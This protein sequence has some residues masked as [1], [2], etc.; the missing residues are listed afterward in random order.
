MRFSGLEMDFPHEEL[1]TDNDYLGDSKYFDSAIITP[2]TQLKASPKLFSN[3]KTNFIFKTKFSE[4]TS[5]NQK[6]YVSFLGRLEF[7][8]ASYSWLKFSYSLM[9]RYYLRTYIDRDVY[10][11]EYHPCYF[12]NETVYISYST[13]ISIKKTWLDFKFVLNNQFYNEHFTEYDHKIM[14][15]EAAVKSKSFKRLALSAAY[16]FYNADNVSYQSSNISESTKIDR[17]YI[18]NGIKLSARKTLKKSFISSFGFKFNFSHRDYAMDSWYY[19]PDLWKQYY[20][21]DLVLE[22]SKKINKAAS[23][24]LSAKHF[25]R[26]VISSESTITDWVEDYKIYRRNEFWLKF[27]YNFSINN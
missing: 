1:N 5:S 19:E 21:Y 26:D 15:F 18:K 4:Y 6:S 3:H 20:E 13:P 2:S 27:I 10:P 12:S 23:L 14:G 24:Q 25:F 22:C 16:I 8:V 11:I 7:K 17:S 9:P